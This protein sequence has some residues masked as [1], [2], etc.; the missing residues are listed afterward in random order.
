[1][2]HFRLYFRL[3]LRKLHFLLEVVSFVFVEQVSFL[4]HCKCFVLLPVPTDLLSEA[5]AS[6]KKERRESFIV[7]GLVNLDGIYISKL[8]NRK[9]CGNESIIVLFSDL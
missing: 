9:G 4:C 2:Y 5:A 3:N 8:L 1:M 7:Y 6:L